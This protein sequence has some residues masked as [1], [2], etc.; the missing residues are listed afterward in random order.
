MTEDADP[1]VGR[2]AS[3]HAIEEVRV[4]LHVHQPFAPAVRATLKVGFGRCRAV[5]RL[6]QLERRRHHRRDRE[7]AEELRGIGIIQRK[8]G[9]EDVAALMARVGAN[10]GIAHVE[11]G[12]IQ[13]GNDAVIATAATVVQLAVPRLRQP[14]LEVQARRD[15]ARHLAVSGHRPTGGYGRR[16]QGSPG[17]GFSAQCITSLLRGDLLLRRGVVVRI[18][19][20]REHGRGDNDHCCRKTTCL[21][22]S[23]CRLHVMSPHLCQWGQCGAVIAAASQHQ[24]T[25]ERSAQ[26]GGLKIQTHFFPQSPLPDTHPAVFDLAAAR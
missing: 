21:D 11:R 17:D 25:S 10:V 5:G 22:F 23:A 8:I 9:A 24:S 16:H 6:D 4:A 18:P 3:D 13:S 2:R 12:Q 7:A 14:H 26:R 19:A 1:V 20:C 15:L